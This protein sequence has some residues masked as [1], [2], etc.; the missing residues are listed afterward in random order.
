MEAEGIEQMML[1][2]WQELKELR[3]EIK[4]M[5]SRN[6]ECVRVLVIVNFVLCILIVVL[7]LK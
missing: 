3:L 2:I 1:K 6:Y 7:L 5:Q 4:L